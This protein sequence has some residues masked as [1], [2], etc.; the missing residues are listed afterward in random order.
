MEFSTRTSS[1]ALRFILKK[2]KKNSGVFYSIRNKRLCSASIKLMSHCGDTER[3]D[4]SNGCRK[5]QGG[6][7]GKGMCVL[8]K[9]TLIYA[10]NTSLL[11]ASTFFHRF[12][13][14]NMTSS[15]MLFFV[16]CSC[17]QNHAIIIP[18]QLTQ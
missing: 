10:I 2:K 3:A 17:S 1:F 4:V 8:V 15:T 14:I 9:T 13:S 7:G 12:F 16:F 11:S 6:G 18:F 5:C